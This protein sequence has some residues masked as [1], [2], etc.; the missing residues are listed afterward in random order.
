MQILSKTV[1]IKAEFPIDNNLIEKRLS[2]MGIVPLRW[3]IVKVDC[4]MLEI[5]VSY[6]NL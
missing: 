2:K 3:A 6:E 1:K 5:S 4:D